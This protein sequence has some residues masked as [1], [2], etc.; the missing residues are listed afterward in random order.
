MR[1]LAQRAARERVHH[2]AEDVV[3][4][5]QTS[6]GVGAEDGA[7]EIGAGVL[8][9]RRE[10]G[11]GRDQMGR[12]MSWMSMGL[13]AQAWIRTRRWSGG[14]GG[15]GY[16]GGEGKAGWIVLSRRCGPKGFTSW[17]EDAM[18]EDGGEF[19]CR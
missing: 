5:F 11:N 1:N 3:A 19:V 7:K 12:F 13:R 18:V 8:G 16:G 6:R 10:A 15:G 14:R 9:A 4:G 2:D 17:G